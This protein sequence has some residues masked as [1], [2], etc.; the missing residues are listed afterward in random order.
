[1]LILFE[2]PD[3]G[4]KSALARATRHEWLEQPGTGYCGTVARHCGPPD[5]P[6][7]DP[8]VEYEVPFE[9]G[10][11]LHSDVLSLSQLVT[12]DRGHT[13]E[14]IYGP[15]YR[16]RSRLTPAGALHCEMTL[17][18]LGAVKVMCLPP[19]EVVQR[20]VKR[21]GDWFINQDHLPAIHGF[22]Q[23]HAAMFGYAVFCQMA[24]TSHIHDDDGTV[25]GC[26]ACF[27]DPLAG[28]ARDVITR[29][30]LDHDLAV[31]LSAA[32]AG[33]WTGSLEPVVILTG[34]K[35]G[36]GARTPYPFTRPFTPWQ[37]GS[38]SE[39]LLDAVLAAGLH[40]STAMVN[41]CYPGV[42][43]R[44][45]RELCPRATFIALGLNAA[46]A[47]ARA[48]VEHRRIPHPQWHRRFRSRD[49]SGY[50]TLLERA[51]GA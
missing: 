18:S 13:G 1:V 15:L 33:T 17:S 27:T 38:A 23:R 29:A 6:D 9:A 8:F 5:P 31:E 37:T 51:A 44:R 11:P 47:L 42:S 28:L 3:G 40:T 39:W 30:M 19:L 49:F 12:L 34:D 43:L 32:S 16:G 22:Y 41:A 46:S 2:G 26:E 10:A 21:R 24:V 50:V 45:I 14:L 7:R 36:P 4:G 48:G 35:P 20:C 25:E